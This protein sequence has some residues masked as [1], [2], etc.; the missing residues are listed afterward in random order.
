MFVFVMLTCPSLMLQG[1]DGLLDDEFGGTG[2]VLGPAQSVNGDC[3]NFAAIHTPGGI[4]RC[5]GYS[6]VG[7]QE[8]VNYSTFLMDG[9][10]SQAVFEQFVGSELNRAYAAAPATGGG[11]FMTGQLQVSVPAPLP[12]SMYVAKYDAAFNLDAAFSVNGYDVTFNA[13]SCGKAVAVDGSGRVVVAGWLFENGESNFAVA[14][15]LSNG[16]LDPSFNSNGLSTIDIGDD[17]HV[18]AIVI[19][20]D[21]K[22]VVA[23]TSILGTERRYAAVR[24]GTDGFLDF[25][26]GVQGKALASLNGGGLNE[27]NDIVL[28]EDGSLLLAGIAANNGVAACGIAA[29]T[30]AGVSDPSFGPGGQG[31]VVLG[32]GANNTQP[33]GLYAIALDAEENIIVGGYAQLSTERFAVARLYSNGQRDISFGNNGVVTTS[34]SGVVGEQRVRDLYIQPD[35]RIVAVGNTQNGANTRFMVVRYLTSLT[36]GVVN[37][38]ERE[39]PMLVYP[40]PLKSGGTIQFELDRAAQVSIALYDTGGRELLQMVQ[41]QKFAP[42]LH[43]V[44][45][46]L[47]SDLTSGSYFVRVITDVGS[48]SVQVIY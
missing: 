18:N 15:Y 5:V 26:F 28:R 31:F 33:S 3:F 30:A 10:Y 13:P 24:L 16:T 47:P 46:N 36:V 11:M 32:A 23:G 2:V 45:F 34:T 6:N 4:T 39:E 22:I 8:Y 1:Q 14:R 42:G 40:V 21:G 44:T 25:G 12:P 37:R 7:E 20:P 17:D 9:T 19:Q 27:C 38:E 43:N 35:H 41:K 29:F 48:R